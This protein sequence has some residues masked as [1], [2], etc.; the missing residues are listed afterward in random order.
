MS[1]KIEIKHVPAMHTAQT[2]FRARPEEMAAQFGT[3]FGKVAE[4]L[5][6]AGVPFDGPA[7]AR[8]VSHDD[9][10]FEV[11]AGFVVP[12][13]VA[14]KGEVSGGELPA[15]EAAVTTHMGTYDSLTEAYTAIETWAKEHGRELDEP[16][17]EFY[18][19]GPETPPAETRT[20]VVWPLKAA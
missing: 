4:Y 17:W 12:A 3:S 18:F 6:Q 16:M 1:H 5:T 20:D 2:H 11:D 9:E 13:A 10:G 8:Y 7:F 15:T 14:G 19:S